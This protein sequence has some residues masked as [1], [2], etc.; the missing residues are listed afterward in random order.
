MTIRCLGVFR[1]TTNSPN[2]ESDDALILKAVT[3]ELTRLGAETHLIEPGSLDL[4]K[5]GDWD[6]ILPMC[7]N[8]PALVSL[9][10]IGA[11]KNFPFMI[12]H[13]KAVLG[14]YRNNMSP[15]LTDSCPG[16]FPRT[17]MRYVKD[18][19]GKAPGFFNGR[20]RAAGGAW[21]KRGDVHNTCDH[22]VVYVKRWQDAAAVRDD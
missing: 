16:I 6:V 11:W 14:C 15:V 2:R 1:E 22:D 19:P 21:I 7:E 12:N 5:P 13:P 17:E 3:E 20:S 8:Y 18:I 9:K 4:V 10:R